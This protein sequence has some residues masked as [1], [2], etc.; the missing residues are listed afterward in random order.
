[1][2]LELTKIAERDANAE[3]PDIRNMMICWDLTA[4]MTDAPAMS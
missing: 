3:A 4:F 1:M 2:A